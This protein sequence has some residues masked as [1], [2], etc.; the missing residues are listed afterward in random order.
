[1]YPMDF[2]EFLLAIGNDTLFPAIKREILEL[3]RNDIQK[4]AKGSE[5]KAE[6]IFDEIPAQLS[7]H[8][9]KIQAFFS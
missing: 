1:M 6:S 7:K 9:K 3:Y 5:L 8:E 4:H 2:E